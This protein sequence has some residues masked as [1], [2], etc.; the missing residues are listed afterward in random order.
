MVYIIKLTYSIDDSQKISWDK[1]VVVSWTIAIQNKCSLTNVRTSRVLW[2]VSAVWMCFVSNNR[3]LDSILWQRNV[4]LLQQARIKLPKEE[5]SAASVVGDKHTNHCSHRG[6]RSKEMSLS[7]R[8]IA[9]GYINTS[10]QGC[11]I[12]VSLS[13]H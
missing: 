9:N 5:K 3:L 13:L 7:T 6:I 8:V 1:N 10:S 2:L 11:N 12:T 4:S